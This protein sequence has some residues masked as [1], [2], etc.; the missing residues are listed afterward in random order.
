MGWSF[1]APGNAL[2]VLRVLSPFVAQ[3]GEKQT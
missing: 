1:K 3:A 2:A